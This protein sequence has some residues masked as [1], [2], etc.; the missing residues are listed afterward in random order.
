MEGRVLN[1]VPV[2]LADVEVG[3]NFGDF[4][5][6]NVVGGAPYFLGRRIVLGFLSLDFN[7]L[8]M[9]VGDAKSERGACN[10]TE[11][12]HD[13]SASPSAHDQ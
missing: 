2:Y 3:A 4:G 6:G 12:E 13:Q 5:K 9:S 11:D 8:Q 7:G 10:G 1:A